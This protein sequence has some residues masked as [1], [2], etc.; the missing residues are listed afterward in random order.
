M[1]NSL[2]LLVP[3]RSSSLYR[4]R[5]WL[6]LGRVLVDLIRRLPVACTALSGRLPLCL[7]L[8]LNF[9]IIWCRV[10]VH[11]SPRLGGPPLRVARGCRFCRRVLAA[12]VR[13]R[14]WRMVP[15]EGG[16]T[17]NDA[18]AR[19]EAWVSETRAASARCNAAPLRAPHPPSPSHPM[20]ARVSSA[21]P[22]LFRRVCCVLVVWLS[23]VCLVAAVSAGKPAATELPPDPAVT[24]ANNAAF[25]P[26]PLASCPPGTDYL[27][28]KSA[29]KWYYWCQKWAS[30]ST[31]RPRIDET[32]SSSAAATTAAALAST[33]ASTPPV[34]SSSGRSHPLNP[35]DTSHGQ[36][37]GGD[38]S[39]SS[40]G[41]ADE[42]QQ[43]CSHE[44]VCLKGSGHEQDQGGYEPHSEAFAIRLS[45]T[46]GL[47]LESMGDAAQRDALL[48]R[49]LARCVT[50]PL[51]PS[52]LRVLSVVSGSTVATFDI[53]PGAGPTTSA[54][55]IQILEAMSAAP[56]ATATDNIIL[57]NA[58]GSNFKAVQMALCQDG[59]SWAESCLPAANA[60]ASNQPL[61]GHLMVVLVGVGMLCVLVSFGCLF[62]MWFHRRQRGSIL[63]APVVH[64]A[65][66]RGLA[67]P[68]KA[69]P[70]PIPVHVRSSL[71]GVAEEEEVCSGVLPSHAAW[72]DMGVNSPRPQSAAATQSTQGSVASAAEAHTAH[73]PAS[74]S[75]SRHA[76]D[77]TSRTTADLAH[78]I[79]AYN[80]QL[81]AKHRSH[82]VSPLSADA[83]RLARSE[84]LDDHDAQVVRFAKEAQF[85]A[86]SHRSMMESSVHE[87]ATDT[88]TPRVGPLPESLQASATPTPLFCADSAPAS[89]QLMPRTPLLTATPMALPTFDLA[90]PPSSSS[91]SGSR[92]SQKTLPVLFPAV[93]PRP[94]ALEAAFSPSLLSLATVEHRIPSKRTVVD[95]GTL[96]SRDPNAFSPCPSHTPDETIVGGAMFGEQAAW[97]QPRLDDS[98]FDA[99]IAECS[100]LQNRLDSPQ[101]IADTAAAAAAETA[102]VVQPVVVHPVRTELVVCRPL[103]SQAGAA[104]GAGSARVS[105]TAAQAR[106]QSA[107]SGSSAAR[108]AAAAAVFPPV[109]RHQSFSMGVA[110]LPTSS[111]SP[112]PRLLETAKSLL[113]PS[114]P[115]RRLGFAV[116]GQSPSPAHWAVGRR[117]PSV[118]VSAAASSCV[119][120]EYDGPNEFVVGDEAD[121]LSA[122]RSPRESPQFDA[123]EFDGPC[124]SAMSPRIAG[125]VFSPRTDRTLHS[126]VADSDQEGCLAP[127]Q[128]TASGSHVRHAFVSSPDVDE[129]TR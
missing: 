82:F 55:A 66:G 110:P 123:A 95:S 62:A 42:V 24:Y 5:E 9:V 71:H 120:S 53:L 31:G 27:K 14:R 48:A 56:N 98:R 113:P 124:G 59:T 67:M 85:K 126:A 13:L 18:H 116:P 44:A 92:S 125:T 23:L 73:E 61:G 99:N 96:E 63:P 115:P 121:L 80:E 8:P 10:V 91:S 37:H 70:M 87:T 76:S 111:G 40:T 88:Q 51:P 57:A 39:S 7:L 90:E 30:S 105:P 25:S 2:R 77:S 78:A 109:V 45:I 22:P 4:L 79:Q 117:Q 93:R 15:I 108:R 119:L 129:A 3:C 36:G 112:T 94:V 106:A 103:S 65:D 11:C 86:Y 28:T 69:A 74:G 29:G 60:P 1:H 6:G 127:V 41:A 35:Q 47:E 17:C 54:A 83:M 101:L 20:T 89:S 102:V 34:V 104:A 46:L 16:H 128:S 12:V 84:M 52:R 114:V 58:I 97:N 107:S 21:H 50:P 33:G 38:D 100:Q 81:A 68:K 43:F 49:D 118:S 32:D 72:R 26:D 122:R 64:S 19:A 75:H